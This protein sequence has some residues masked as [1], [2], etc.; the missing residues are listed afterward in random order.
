M[1]ML[2]LMLMVF[3]LSACGDTQDLGKIRDQANK[4]EQ[5]GGQPMMDKLGFDNEVACVKDGKK[6]W[7]KFNDRK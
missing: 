2:I 7:M 4:C 6:T 5:L 3:S 1:K